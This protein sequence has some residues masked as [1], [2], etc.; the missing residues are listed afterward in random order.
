MNT[1]MYEN[2]IVAANIEKLAGLGYRFIEP[3]E[4]RL[5]CGDTGTGALAA[6]EL[7]VEE[8]RR[9]LGAAL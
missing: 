9:L 8:V 3:R 4:G 2:P 7:I 6:V 1:A 5:A